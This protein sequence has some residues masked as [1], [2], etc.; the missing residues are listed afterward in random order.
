ML[1]SP[2]RGQNS[3]NG[4][5]PTPPSSTSSLN[6]NGSDSTV[7]VS[8]C[9]N[10]SG[11]ESEN[12]THTTVQHN[13]HQSQNITSTAR[14]TNENRKNP[15]PPAPNPSQTKGR[16]EEQLWEQPNSRMNYAAGSSTNRFWQKFKY[17]LEKKKV[18]VP[19]TAL[20]TMLCVAY[21]TK[22]STKFI[23]LM[24]VN[25][26]L[27]ALT[28]LGGAMLAFFAL[29]LCWTLIQSTIM[30]EHK[31]TKR[32]LEPVLNEV[33]NNL[34][35]NEI[36]QYITV[37]QSNGKRSYFELHTLQ[38]PVDKITII[39]GKDKIKGYFLSD[40]LTA[41]FKNRIA[42]PIL[43]TA[44]VFGNIAFPLVHSGVSLENL[45]NPSVYAGAYVNPHSVIVLSSL[46]LIMVACCILY[47]I[48]NTNSEQKICLHNKNNAEPKK[49]NEQFVESIEKVLS[50]KAKVPS[51]ITK[52]Q[53]YYSG[54]NDPILFSVS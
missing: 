54:S 19:F 15:I 13:R 37:D 26:G 23:E 27:N 33:K 47:N 44:V 8:S 38:A 49:A 3:N 30:K 41:I 28:I 51:R 5:S 53:V 34:P 21:V 25:N 24:M 9:P 29:S 40:S 18:T 14:S 17:L 2:P 46:A 32:D 50:D 1:T 12:L 42:V 6:G 10:S 7:I 35:D 52:I 48:Y 31:I 43:L 36:I 16:E 11:D 45:L 4:Q 22:P 20:V 39:D